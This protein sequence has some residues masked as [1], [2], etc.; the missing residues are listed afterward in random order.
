MLPKHCTEIVKKRRKIIKKN[1][2]H[3]TPSQQTQNGRGATR[4]ANSPGG[5]AGPGP[6]LVCDPPQP[7]PPPRVLRDSGL[8]TWR[9]RRPLF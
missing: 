2:V 3:F 4:G 5:A 9:Q 8:G 1:A 6:A 7:P